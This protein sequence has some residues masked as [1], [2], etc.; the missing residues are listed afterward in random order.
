MS[1]TGAQIRAARSLIGLAQNE[2]VELAG[3]SI[4]TYRRIEG[5]DG[6]PNASAKTLAAIQK[7]LEAAGVIFIPENGEGVG[8][9]LKKGENGEVV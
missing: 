3:T 6:V 2:I 7:A 5:E 9:R 1:L 4:A 8:V